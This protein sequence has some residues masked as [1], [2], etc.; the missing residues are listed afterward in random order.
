MKHRCND[1]SKAKY[2]RDKGI[3]VCNEWLEYDN[4]Y[5]WCIDNGLKKN[6]DLD[7]ID[8][9]KNYC[10]SNCQFITHKENIRKSSVEINLNKLLLLSIERKK[11]Y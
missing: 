9:T 1:K 8:D 10:P 5:K 3:Q 7:R 6:L 2:Y 11:E 4:F